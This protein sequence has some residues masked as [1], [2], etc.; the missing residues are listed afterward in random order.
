MASRK[1]QSDGYGFQSW[2]A[3]EQRNPS[4]TEGI[5]VSEVLA[6]LLAGTDVAPSGSPKTLKAAHERLRE[7][8]E[9][10]ADA[11]GRDHRAFMNGSA[12]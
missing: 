11:L 4:E 6:A 12:R 7:E 9:G 5:P 8:V 2:E 10:V 3:A 1:K